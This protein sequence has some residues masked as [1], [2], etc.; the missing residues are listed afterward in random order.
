M[1]KG[2]QSGKSI[3]E[4]HNQGRSAAVAALLI[5][6]PGHLLVGLPAS[7]EEPYC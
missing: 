7:L 2:V 3:L 5:F 1:Q 4:Q 6:S